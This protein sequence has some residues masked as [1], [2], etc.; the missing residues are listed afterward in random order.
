MNECISKYIAC[1][2]ISTVFDIL[3]IIIIILNVIA[4]DVTNN[5]TV[6]VVA[7]AAV[8]GVNECVVPVAEAAAGVVALRLLRLN[9]LKKL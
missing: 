3:R 9:C 7:F 5:D 8:I 2:A 1:Y 4:N 6:I